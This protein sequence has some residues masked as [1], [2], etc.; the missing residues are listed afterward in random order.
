M[1]FNKTDL[2]FIHQKGLTQKK[3][4]QQLNLLKAGLPFINLERA[5]TIDDGILQFSYDKASQ[6]ISHYDSRKDDLKVVKFVPAS[7][8]AT[9]F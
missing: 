1:Q 7:G 9:S 4:E 8:A 2:Q 5:A 6:L 3:V